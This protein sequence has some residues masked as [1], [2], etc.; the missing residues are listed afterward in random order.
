MDNKIEIR[1]T[2]KSDLTQLPWLYRQYFKGDTKIE[3]NYEGMTKKF[4]N[5]IGNEDYKFVSAMHE[6]KLVGFCSVVV[7]HDIVEQQKPILMLWNL[8]VHPEYRKQ[9]IGKGIMTF[10][11]ELG[12]SIGADSIFLGCNIEN[13]NAQKFYTKLGYNRSCGFY[14]YL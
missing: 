7:N 4:E 14:K 1:F 2:L 9:N 8:R 13:E 12:R 6:D 3:T 5:L 10:V 11:E